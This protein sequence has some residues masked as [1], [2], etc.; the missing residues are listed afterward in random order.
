ME[1]RNGGF[2]WSMEHNS[3]FEID[4][5]AVLH[6]TTKRLADPANPRKTRPIPRPELKLHGQTI[7][8]VDSYKYLGVMV[9]NKLRWNIQG[10]RATSKATKWIMMFR[11]L[12]RPSTGI[13]AK[14]MRRLYI[15]V[16]IPKMTYGADV[17]YTPPRLEM[18]KRRREG[19]V[20]ILRELGKIQRIATLTING[21]LRTTAS[22]TLDAHANLL[23]IDLL[24]EKICHR[25]LIRICSLPDT[26]P[27][28]EVVHSYYN[29]PSR[30]Q[31][32][33]LQNLL[34]IFD[35]NP[36]QIKSS[37]RHTPSNTQTRI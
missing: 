33:P 7:Q 3:K 13:S 8:E 16:A 6:C 21:A 28:R 20:G 36:E 2:D 35:I 23:P 37:N 25:A 19:S 12:T 22:D 32:T 27:L 18:G 24:M 10:K 4:K 29:N 30:R 34:R 15:T 1:D 9:D 26:H 31:P 5:L 14:L 17:W 11:R